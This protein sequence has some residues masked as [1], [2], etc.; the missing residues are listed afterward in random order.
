[1]EYSVRSR[2]RQW[3]PVV[4]V[5]ILL[6]ISL[7]L[8]NLATYNTKKTDYFSERQLYLNITILVILSTVI[9][10][11]LIRAFYQWRTRQAGSRFTIKIMSGFI[12]LTLLPALVIAFFSIN[13]LGSRIDGWFERSVEGALDDSVEL[14][15]LSLAIRTRQ[16]LTEL[17]RLKNNLNNKSKLEISELL[18][19]FREETGAHEVMLLTEAQRIYA[20]SV[21]DT[22]TLIPLFPARDLFRA[23]SGQTDSYSHLEPVGQDSLFSRVAWSVKYGL[24]NDTGILTALFPISEREQE[25]SRS[26]ESVRSEYKNLSFQRN[27]FKDAFRITLLMI[28]V[29]TA[30][31]SI[32]AAFVFSRRLT[33]PVRVLVE[34]TLAV[35][36]GNLDKK[37]PVSQQDDF[38]LLS[39][40][41]NNM[42]QRLSEA[43]KEREIARQQLQQEHDYLNV[44][45]EHLSSG[46][47]TLDNEGIIRRM[48]T[49]AAN[50]LKV[51]IKDWVG[52]TLGNAIA[53]SPHLRIFQDAFNLKLAQIEQSHA[54]EWQTEISIEQQ[55]KRLLLVC[56]GA[57]LPIDHYGQRGVVLVFDDVSD[58]IQAE[59]DA[60]WGEVARRLAHEI[61]NPLTPIQLSA[62]RLVRKLEKELSEDSAQFLKRMTQTIIQQVDN[63]K[64]M[65]NAFSDYAK[66]PAVNLQLADLNNL[67]QDTAE[68]YKANEKQ[69]DIHL[70]LAPHLPKLRLDTNRMRQ[71]LIN[72]IK[73]ALEALD[74]S[75]IKGCI[76][77]K[78][79]LHANYVQ[80]DIADNGP[81]IP[82]ELLPRLFEPYVTS[83][84]KGT[85]LG[86]AIVKKIVEEHS[87]SISAH[88]NSEKGAM[89]SI[90]FPLLA[91]AK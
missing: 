5:F 14:S 67:V 26:V 34:G 77:L 63:L 12:I 52:D 68:L 32:W 43:Q 3:L 31:F 55:H 65:V 38:N 40:S 58:L 35:A 75:N 81:G 88:N 46:V 83:K 66:T 18:E 13:F 74:D 15:Q 23:F 51:N 71:L 9:I 72:L 16:H 22:D 85:G 6:V 4:L 11:N 17:G 76:T 87:G 54:N 1:M 19:R 80:L 44:V 2:I 41:F 61:K 79:T 91:D 47:I 49:T 59:H 20:M 24:D 25:L 29:L 27:Q 7:N 90:Q 48:N 70:E 56:R 86:L 82:T 33:Q 45:L 8:L 28:M 62:E 64:S 50:I 60:A 37:I 53:H 42:T 10:I 73:N 36:S 69:A 84:H 57:I 89:I 21:S 78:T 39:T 30:L